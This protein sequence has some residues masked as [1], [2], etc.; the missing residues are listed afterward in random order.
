M[1]NLQQM[2]SI[3]YITPGLDPCRIRIQQSLDLDPN[4]EKCLETYPDPDSGDSESGTMI[5]IY[6]LKFWPIPGTAPPPMLY[7]AL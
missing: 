1:L 7:K 2:C 5:Q 6:P 3:F 4:L